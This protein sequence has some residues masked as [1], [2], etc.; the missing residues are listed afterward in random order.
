MLSWSFLSLSF[1]SCFFLRLCWNLQRADGTRKKTFK[2]EY[3]KILKPQLTENKMLIHPIEGHNK[4][5]NKH[6]ICKPIYLT[7]CS[8]L[9]RN[10]YKYFVKWYYKQVLRNLKILRFAGPVVWNHGFG[11]TVWPIFRHIYIQ[12]SFT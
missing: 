11:L 1:L 7:I 3:K 9:I 5:I 12:V 10:S 6:L 8:R 4:K 2:H